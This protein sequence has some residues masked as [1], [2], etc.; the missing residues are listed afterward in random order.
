ME[1]DSIPVRKTEAKG[2]P[3]EELAKIRCNNTSNRN[4]TGYGVTYGVP[5]PQGR[6]Q[7]PQNAALAIKL[8]EGSIAPI[9]W[10]IAEKWPDGSVRWI[11]LDFEMD[12]PAN[13][14][15]SFALVADA[16]T[17]DY[18]K[19]EIHE[20]N[21]SISVANKHL[22]VEVERNSF[23]LFESLSVNGQELIQQG[24]DIIVV[25]PKGKRYY[26]SFTQNLDVSIVEQG[27]ERVV[28]ESSGRHTASDGD[29]LLSFRLRYTIRPHDPCIRLSYKMANEEEPEMGVHLGRIFMEIPTTL[30]PRPTR[31]V[32]QKHH[33][34]LWFTRP[35]EIQENVELQAGSFISE[36]AESVYGKAHSGKVVIR[37]LH[38]FR[39]DL[40]DYPH[41]LRPGNARSDMSGGLRAAYPFLATVSENGSFIGWFSEMEANHPKGVASERNKIRFDIWPQWADNLRLNRGMSKEHDIF[42]SFDDRR[43]SFEDLES[44][45]FDHE[46]MGFGIFA[47]GAPPVN[48]SIDPEYARE[49]EVFDIHRWLPYDE[50]RYLKIETKMGTIGSKGGKMSRGM[51]DYGDGIIRDCSANNENDRILDRFREYYR[52][53]KAEFRREALISARHNAHVDLISYDPDELRQGTM[54]AHCPNHSDGACYPSHMWVGGLLAAFCTTGEPDFEEAA[55]SVGENMLRWQEKCPEVF[56]CDSREAGW[57]MLAWVQ[58]WH[59]N[60]E[61][62]W[63]DAADRVF[64]FYA[65]KVDEEG[66]IVYEIPHKLGTFL[67]GYGEF[68]AWR[69]CFH[70]YEASGKEEVKDFLV[71]VLSKE[72]IYKITPAR[73]EKGGWACNDLFPAWAVWQLTGDDKFLKDNFPFLEYMMD[74]EGTFPWTGVDVMY[75]LNALHER[76]EL[77]EFC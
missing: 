38:N 31:Y 40:S 55:I 18:P 37:N 36:M 13:K 20:N 54:A 65:E 59:H 30:G 21:A 60:H 51:L 50:D 44:R 10:K 3:M 26:A 9:Q 16:E 12:L 70:Y 27:P 48:F 28:I 29:Q 24:A 1:N 39:E 73:V 72:N 17:P 15:S 8:P 68:I 46:V 5:L 14:Q 69:G 53:G 56:Y 2:F 67:Q 58:L 57:P 61:Q 77:E 33:T 41:Y 71:D 34:E 4:L 32:R 7:E 11:V 64:Q 35:V 76:G 43:L 49:C 25:N 52:R 47:E 66:K 19:L 42:L 22:R 75:Y 74:R 23:S 6:L 63:L 45:Y 62:R